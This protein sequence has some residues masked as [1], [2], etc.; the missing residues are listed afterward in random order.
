MLVVR[1]AVDEPDLARFLALVRRELGAREAAVLDAGSE[2]EEA[3]GERELR[4]KTPG[5]RLVVARFDEPV[6]DRDVKQRRFEMLVSTFDMVAGDE[7]P[8]PPP[9]SR[10]PA[11]RAL[12][13]ELE[14][15]REKCS[16]QNVLVIDA[17][18]PVLW[19]AARPRDVVAEA[20]N[21]AWAPETDG[22]RDDDADVA[23]RSRQ[24]LQTV[25]GAVDLAALRRG[26]RVRHVERDLGAPLLAHS[27]AG[28]YLLTLV[29]DG[30]FDELRAERSVLESLPRI[31]R[32]VL[33]LPPLDPT[34]V[35]G[36]GVVAFRRPRRR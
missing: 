35:K 28:F 13:E 23:E 2:D 21:A 31:E 15:L 32:L 10:P 7:E 18:S 22:P 17:N 11:A 4:C 25:R 8:P 14:G 26:K 1:I 3:P 29:F 30:S 16:A 36:A 6:A 5:G 34:P 27:F 12:H 24:A 19:A 20:W 9:R 33:A